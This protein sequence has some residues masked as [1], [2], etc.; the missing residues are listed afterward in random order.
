MHAQE[1]SD[2]VQTLRRRPLRV[3][4]VE[5]S[6]L[7]RKHL[8]SLLEDTDGV[9]VCGEVDSEADAITALRIGRFDAVVVDLQLREGSGFGVLQHLKQHHPDLLS[10][11]LTNSNSPAMRA[12][13]MAMGA[14]HFLDKSSEFERVADLL[15][16]LR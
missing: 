1:P 6:L 12:R 14:H 3:L 10:I 4:L 8:V 15:E 7:I 13:S 11:V 5:D 16:G 2:N 9:T